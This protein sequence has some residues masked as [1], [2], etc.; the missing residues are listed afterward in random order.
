MRQRG[1]MGNGEKGEVE[2]VGKGVVEGEGVV[3]S[4]VVVE[5]GAVVTGVVVVGREVVVAGEWSVGRL[6][7]GILLL[8]ESDAEEVEG[9]K[10]EA[11]RMEGWPS[12]LPLCLDEAEM[13]REAEEVAGVRDG[14]R[15]E[16]WPNLLF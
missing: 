8:I 3:E 11:R 5:S 2:V 9:E 1:S 16:A 4:G 6:E 13:V 15:R 10:K 14:R 12:L 7:E